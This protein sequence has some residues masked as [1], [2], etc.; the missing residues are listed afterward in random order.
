[1]VIFFRGFLLVFFADF[2]VDIDILS[3]NLTRLYAQ[4]N[5]NNAHI[6]SLKLILLNYSDFAYFWFRYEYG[7]M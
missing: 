3:S 7:G 2:C 4:L 1:M 6:I 5:S